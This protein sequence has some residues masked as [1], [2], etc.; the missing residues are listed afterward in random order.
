MIPTTAQILNMIRLGE[1]SG[2]E[3]KEVRFNGNRISNPGKNQLAKEIAAMANAKGGWLILGVEDT[4]RRITGVPLEM[5]DSLESYILEICSDTLKPPLP[6]D[7]FR[8]EL[9]DDA[10][11]P[12][13][14]LMVNIE[15]SLY[16]HHTPTAFSTALAAVPVQWIPSSW[17]AFSAN[18]VC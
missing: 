2:V 3:F 18:A 17:S 8:R 16:V 4:T 12:V 5:L 7:I 1:E 11:I 13:R 9:P 14:V 6:I 10:G 15:K